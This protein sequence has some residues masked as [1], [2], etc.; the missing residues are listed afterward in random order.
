MAQ[1]VNLTS[2]LNEKLGGKNSV[3]FPTGLLN[4]TLFSLLSSQTHRVF[5]T[6]AVTISVTGNNFMYEA[7][8]SG[9]DDELRLFLKSVKAKVTKLIVLFFF[10][11]T[12]L[13]AFEI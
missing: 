2:V 7:V 6:S 12:M 9:T 3:R 10:C 4:I 5:T 8:G 13:S 1:A 11:L